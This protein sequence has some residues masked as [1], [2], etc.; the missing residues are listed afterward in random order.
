[1][2]NE[3]TKKEFQRVIGAIRKGMGEEYPKAMMTNQQMAHNTATV[4][5]GGEFKTTLYT[6][7]MAERVMNDFSF[8]DFLR[9]YDCT[10]KW[11]ATSLGRIQIRINFK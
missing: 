7:E 4:N 11:E 9:E 6:T 2:L 3:T 1:M 8:Q 10:A 5:C